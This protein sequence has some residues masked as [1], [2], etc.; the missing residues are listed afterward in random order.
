VESGQLC[1][2]ASVLGESTTITI[3][4]LDPLCHLVEL[5]SIAGALLRRM[6]LT[7]V[8]TRSEAEARTLASSSDQR[9]YP[10]L[11]TP[12]DTGGEKPFEEFISADES[13]RPWLPGLRAIPHSVSGR[14]EPMLSRLS[15]I[16]SVGGAEPDIAL[17]IS[18]VFRNQFDQFHHKSSTKNLDQRL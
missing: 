14:V 7:P 9:S 16:L 3:P 13:D 2:L 1:L 11:L 6:Q 18:T 17:S 8:F 4:D 12:L 10:I 5:Q 15:E